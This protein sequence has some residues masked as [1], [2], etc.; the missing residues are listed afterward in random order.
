M[1]SPHEIES[2]RLRMLEARKALEDYE[3]LKGT[4]PSREH[5][6][7]SRIFTNATEVYLKISKN[8]R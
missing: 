3:K 1:A 6:R 8:Q 5:A 7:L 2:A 4:A